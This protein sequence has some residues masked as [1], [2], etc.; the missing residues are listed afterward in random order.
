MEELQGLVS[1]L[2]T[3]RATMDFIFSSSAISDANACR[4]YFFQL[5]IRVS[6]L[7]LR[8]LVLLD[9]LPHLEEI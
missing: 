9:S 3:F 2:T 7:Y 8:Y 6:R 5:L 4:R 1:D